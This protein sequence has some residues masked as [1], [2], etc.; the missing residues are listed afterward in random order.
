M[1]TN[2]LNNDMEKELIRTINDPKFIEFLN[3][4]LYIGYAVRY[5]DI[6]FIITLN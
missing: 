3:G 4:T 2:N 6:E 1:E 5:G